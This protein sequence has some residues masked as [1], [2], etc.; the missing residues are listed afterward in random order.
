MLVQ[1]IFRFHAAQKTKRTSA[2]TV[3]SAFREQSAT[4]L[5]NKDSKM[6]CVQDPVFAVYLPNMECGLLFAEAVPLERG[7]GAREGVGGTGGGG[8]LKS[9]GGV[10][11]GRG[12]AL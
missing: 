6:V 12:H 9:V 5:G 11:V 1:C 8:H 4:I 10:E 7:G 2:P 3:L